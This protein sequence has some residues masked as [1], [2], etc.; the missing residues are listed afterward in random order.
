M[1][2]QSIQPISVE[3]KMCDGLFVKSMQVAKAHTFIPQH[4]HE[5]DHLSMLASGAVRVWKNGESLGEFH[6]PAGILIE[7]HAKH[8]FMTLVDNTIVYCIHNIRDAESVEVHA[9]HQFSDA[10]IEGFERDMANFRIEDTAADN[11]PVLV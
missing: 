5:Y 9:E 6:A 3:I 1:I 8:K 4:S 2:D 10:D 7:R 11:A